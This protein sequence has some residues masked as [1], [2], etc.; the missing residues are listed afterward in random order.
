MNE[1]I[2]FHPTSDYS[3]DNNSQGRLLLHGSHEYPTYTE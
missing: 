1:K 3:S 2:T